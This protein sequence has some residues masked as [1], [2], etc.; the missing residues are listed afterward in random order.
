MENSHKFDDL[1]CNI[2]VNSTLKIAE[3]HEKE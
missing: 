2:C 1:E 3:Q